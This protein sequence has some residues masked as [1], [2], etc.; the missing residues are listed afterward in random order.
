MFA[1]DGKNFY[2]AGP[3]E[4]VVEWQFDGECRQIAVKLPPGL[5]AVPIQRGMIGECHAIDVVDNG[6]LFAAG[7]SR[8]VVVFRADGEAVYHLV[9]EAK[10]DLIANAKANGNAAGNN[11]DRLAFGGHFSFVRFSPDGQVLA[12]VLSHKPDE[13]RLVEAKTGASCDG[14]NWRVDG[15]LGFLARRPAIGCHRTR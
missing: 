10:G 14:S 15:P 3:G 11:T 2:T 6:E 12:A 4:D 9:N 5:D 8:G 1:A 7:T 13:L